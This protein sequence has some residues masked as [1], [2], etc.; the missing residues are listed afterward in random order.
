[1]NP[2]H[3]LRLLFVIASLVLGAAVVHA[4]DL[5][6]VKARMEQRVGSIDALKDRG[7]VGEN[8]RGLLE[9]RG[10]LAGPEQSLVSDENA[11]RRT[12]YAAIATQTKTSADEVGKA[13][14]Q[15]IASNSKHGVWVQGADGNWA[16]K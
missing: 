7:A 16:Q 1:M 2:A 12:V 8:N 15:K 11:D 5:G 6:A 3:L 14:A 4:E 13:R 10:N 9:A